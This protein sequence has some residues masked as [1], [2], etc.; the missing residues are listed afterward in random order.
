MSDHGP[1]RNP[2]DRPWPKRPDTAHH[3]LDVYETHL[4]V[5]SS[6]A[7]WASIARRLPIGELD[8]VAGLTTEVLWRSDAGASQ[9]HV[10]VYV[11]VD[12]HGNPALLAATAAHEATHVAAA[13]FEHINHRPNPGNEPFAYL[14]G[15]LTAWIFDRVG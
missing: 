5:T 11:D 2:N 13:I 12:A 9:H 3:V 8:P 1:D 15:W 6:R 4:H 7:G 10:V 14:V